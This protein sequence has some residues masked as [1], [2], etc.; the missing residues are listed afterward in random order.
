[1]ITIISGTNRPQS[2]TR[3]ISNQLNQL[4]STKGKRKVNQVNLEDIPHEMYHD[5]MYNA[6]DQHGALSKIQD[7]CMIPSDLWVI[8]TPEYNGSYSGAM[9]IFIDALSVRKY[10]ETFKGKKVALVGV[11][12]GRAGNLRGMEHLTGLL[13][14]L[15]MTVYPNKLP[16]SSIENQI[17]EEGKLKKETVEL[18]ENWVG[19]VLEF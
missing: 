15:G 19:G 13:N 1:M 6:D 14:Y 9:K 3:L 12:A 8:V 16:I 7:D 10:A 11:A 5:K 2:R 18:L 17:D 4:L